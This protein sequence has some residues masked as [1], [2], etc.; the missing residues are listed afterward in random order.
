MSS[1]TEALE[2]ITVASGFRFNKK[3]MSLEEIERRLSF[4]PFRLSN[5]AYEYYQWAGAP[6]G[7]CRP[8]D[9]DGF[10]NNSSTY[11]CSLEGLLEKA[12]DLIHFLSIEEAEKYYSPRN[13]DIYDPK[14]LP[15]VSYENGLLVIVGSLT[16]AETSPVLQ[17]EDANKDRLWFPSLTNMMLAIAESLETVGSILPSLCT[18]YEDEDYGTDEY[19]KKIR[20]NCKIVEAIAKKYGSPRGIILTN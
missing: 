14:C 15:F 19:D 13:A 5:E 4:F 6:T 3:G 1:L 9:W 18:R 7:D 2:R 12:D 17:R 16:P 10:Y 8:D 20:E 11:K